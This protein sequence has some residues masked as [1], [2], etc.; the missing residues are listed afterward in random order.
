[1]LVTLPGIVT[2]VR[3]VQKANAYVPMLVTLSGIVTL[4]RLERAERIVSDAGDAAGNRVTSA[5]ASWILNE[6]GQALVEQHSIRTA[7]KE[8]LPDPPL[9]LSG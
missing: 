6:R 5:H 2:L 1:M 3:P 9:W 7:I 8:I 4:V